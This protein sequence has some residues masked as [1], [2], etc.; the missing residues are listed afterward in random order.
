[1]PTTRTEPILPP[2]HPAPMET[3]ADVAEWRAR[4]HLDG[5]SV[6]PDDTWHDCVSYGRDRSPS[7]VPEA[8]DEMD[9]LTDLAKQIVGDLSLVDLTAIAVIDQTEGTDR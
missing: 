6:H 3:V 8:A 9:R 5:Y 1:M 4:L 7:F 2:C